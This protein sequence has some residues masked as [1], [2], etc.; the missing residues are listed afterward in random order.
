MRG[1]NGT[2]LYV[3]IS[4]HGLIS[5]NRGYRLRKLM[6]YSQNLLEELPQSLEYFLYQLDDLNLDVYELPTILSKWSRVGSA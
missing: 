5:P 6:L 2:I 4:N 1:L 3:C